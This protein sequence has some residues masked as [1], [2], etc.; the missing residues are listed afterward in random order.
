MKT[1][2]QL[3]ERLTPEQKHQKIYYQYKDVTN[4]KP[5]N[6]L[7]VLKQKK[8]LQTAQIAPI[9]FSSP[10][11]GILGVDTRS[12]KQRA[13]DRGLTVKG[14]VDFYDTDWGKM[15]GGPPKGP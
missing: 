11:K 10:I 13:R 14:Q 7:D 1:F 2:K 8:G 12:E 9:P 3:M 15:Q 5:I 4:P 6:P